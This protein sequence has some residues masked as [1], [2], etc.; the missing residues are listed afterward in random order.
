[1]ELNVLKKGCDEITRRQEEQ[2]NKSQ[3]G[4]VID[5][6]IN[7]EK[8]AEANLRLLWVLK[9]ANLEGETWSYLKHYRDKEWFSKFNGSNITLRRI[10]YTS[11]GI[12]RAP[13]DQWSDLPWSNDDKCFD[14]LQELAIM[15][16]KKV[17]GG[18]QSNPDTIANAYQ[19]NRELLQ[20]QIKVYDPEVVIFGNTMK[21]VELSDF[22]GLET[23]QKQVSEGNNHYYDTGKKLYIHAWHPACRGK[24]FT[25]EK[26]V[27]DIVRIVREWLK[28]NGGLQNSPCEILNP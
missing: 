14:A 16:I 13:N 26:Y 4:Y 9:E 8:Y 25:D 27:M 11:Y 18:N 12:L 5:G 28:K 19:E 1:M 2:S 17:P 10:I 22:D 3:N 20:R 6:V 15:N 21:C 23:A 24:D 7:P